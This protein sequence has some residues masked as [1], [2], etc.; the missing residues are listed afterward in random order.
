MAKRKS[1]KPAGERLMIEAGYEPSDAE[2]ADLGV[3]LSMPGYAVLERI[4][5]GVVART[6]QILMCANPLDDG[7]E[8][9]VVELHRRAQVAEGV[10]EEIRRK[11]TGQQTLLA[12][13]PDPETKPD[14]TEGAFELDP[15][16]Q[17]E[18]EVREL[19]GKN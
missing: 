14:S 17:T 11:I 18:R 12:Q 13:G 6:K 1:V 7:Y 8:K 9:T 16:A 5:L 19:L 15:F 10:W 4:A 3:I 2:R